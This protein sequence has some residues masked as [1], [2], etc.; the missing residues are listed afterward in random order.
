MDTSKFLNKEGTHTLFVELYNKKFVKRSIFLARRRR[1]KKEVD[2]VE[3]LTGFALLGALVLGFKL[4]GSIVG[5]GI[6]AG[7]V[8]G[9]IIGVFI[10]L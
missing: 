3:G 4:T 2:L 5:A 10:V 7:C 6:I 1:R 9:L 8:L